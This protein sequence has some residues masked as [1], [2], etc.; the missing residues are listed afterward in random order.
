MKSYIDYMN[1]L[2]PSDLM[3]G[4][5]GQGLFAEK[6]PPV[7]TSEDFCT[8]YQSQLAAGKKL[9]KG[10]KW[11]DYIRYESIRNI[12]IPRPLAIPNP[13]AYAEL[14]SELKNNWA[15]LQNYFNTVT[16]SQSHKNSRIHVRKMNGSSAI[17]QM[18]YKNF[19]NDGNPQDELIKYSRYKVTADIASCFPSIYTHTIPWAIQ[20]KAASKSDV[21]HWSDDI[22]EKTRNTKYGETSGILIGPHASNVISEI[23]L[24]R[25]DSTL[26][27]EGFLYFRC[28]DDYTCYCK[29][30]EEAERFL[31]YLNKQLKEYELTINHKKTRITQLPDSSETDWIMRLN[32]IYLGNTYNANNQQVVPLGIL[33][34]YLD[35]ATR[36]AIDGNDAVPLNYVI[37]VLSSK[38]LGNRAKEYYIS[39][40]KH[41]VFSYPYLAP[42]MQEY[43][44]TPFSV[45]K[46]DINELA[47]AMYRYGFEHDAYEASS[48][49]LY[50]AIVNDIQ[51]NIESE[52]KVFATQDCV[53]MTLSFVYSS[54]NKL[55]KVILNKYKTEAANLLA[56]D[57]DRYWLFIYEV[58]PQTRLTDSF[59]NIK[60]NRISFI[61]KEIKD[62]M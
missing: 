43:V 32:G 14:C 10:N 50:W 60:K 23:I 58:L 27:N 47:N 7:F 6:I 13:F 62:K 4:L 59:K 8:Y 40:L 35:T 53:F 15:N 57:F 45:S 3:D 11:C 41:L 28:I 61:K 29:T 31:A 34:T 42:L 2:S 5:L 18:N 33:K 20:G 39:K 36:I 48:Y 52:D 17:F 30:K 49:A 21:K 54:I 37:K 51:L 38:Y 19:L 22:D 9:G 56:T 24:C 26:V 1:E 12:C 55:G 44:F 46:S 16:S 25:I